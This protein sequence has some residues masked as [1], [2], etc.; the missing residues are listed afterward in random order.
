[1]EGVIQHHNMKENKV[2]LFTTFYSV[3][4]AYSLCNVVEDQL[5]MFTMHGYKIDLLVDE[6]LDES[7]LSGVWKHPNITLKKFMKV[8]R[9]NEGILADNFQDQANQLYDQ[10]KELLKDTQVV[11]AHDIIL[12]PAHIIHNIACR[13]VYIWHTPVC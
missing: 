12:Q 8:D 10:L 13:R 9:S 11:I 5:K 4:P 2:T 7:T 3:D 1:M 6:E